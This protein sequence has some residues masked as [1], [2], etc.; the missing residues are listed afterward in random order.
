MPQ[1]PASTGYKSPG[2]MPQTAATAMHADRGTSW[3]PANVRNK[4]LLYTTT[5]Q[6]GVYVFLYPHRT[7]VGEL[8]PFADRPQGLCIDGDGNV[9]VTSQNDSGG[10][11]IFKLRH[12][13]ERPV[14]SLNDPG[15]PAGCQ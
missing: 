11:T 6:G 9:F 4:D 8:T 5:P 13:S 3:M 15:V 12:G 7:L 14:A 2:T 1:A 10:G